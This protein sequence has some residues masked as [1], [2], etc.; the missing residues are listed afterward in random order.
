MKKYKIANIGNDNSNWFDME[1]TDEQLKIVI[2]L[3][4]ENNK[5][6]TYCCTPHLYIYEYDENKNDVQEYKLSLNRDYEE[7]NKDS[8][9][10]G[11]AI[12]VEDTRLYATE[13]KKYIDSLSEDELKV[14][15]DS[16]VGKEYNG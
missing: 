9:K 12:S 3:F 6:A 13:L 16:W 5:I 11:L 14:F 4:E 1:L 10:N 2:E 15:I 8:K 7:L